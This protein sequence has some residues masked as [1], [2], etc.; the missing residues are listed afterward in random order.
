MYYKKVAALII[1][2]FICFVCF[3][4]PSEEEILTMYPD[5]KVYSK[6]YG[7]TCYYSEDV[8]ELNTDSET[9]YYK[10]FKFK[11]LENTYLCFEWG[12]SGARYLWIEKNGKNLA[13]LNGQ[14]VII[15]SVGNI[16][17]DWNIYPSRTYVTVKYQVK[18]DTIVEVKQPFYSVGVKQPARAAFSILEEPVEGAPVV[19]NI[20]VDTEVEVVGIK[21]DDGIKWALI[22]SKLGLLGWVK[23]FF[24]GPWLANYQPAFLGVFDEDCP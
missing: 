14:K 12:P 8:V 24:V 3:A 19:A 18:D 6:P 16:Y 13:D 20:A 7:L 11:N 5:L 9:S 17:I 2:L 10:I 21:Y 4:F 15:T 23:P 1:C 22:K